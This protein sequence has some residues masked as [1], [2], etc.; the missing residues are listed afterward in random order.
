MFIQRTIHRLIETKLFHHKAIVV[1]GPR[2]VGKTTLMK[3]ILKSHP[4]KSLYLNCDEPDVRAS[5]TNKTSTEL[6][7]YIGQQEL[8]VIDEAQR[9]KNIGLTLKLLIDAAPQI[10]II[11]TGSSAFELSNRISE[12]LTGRTYEYQLFPLSH[13]E[14]LTFSNQTEIQR[15]LERRLIYGMYPDII[16]NDS[17]AETLLRNITKNYLY[18]DVLEYERIKNPDL[19]EKLLQALALQIGNEVSYTELAQILGVDK[20]TV[21]SYIRILEQ[22]FIIYIL[23]PFSRNLRKELG[24]LR[25]IYYYDLGIRNALINNF[26]PI[27]LRQ[28][29]GAIWENFLI[30]ERIKCFSNQGLFPNRY[31]WRTWDKQEIDYIEESGGQLSGFEIKW[32]DKISS[33]PKSWTVTYPRAT[34]KIINRNNYMKFVTK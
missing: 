4:K 1:Y 12:P 17:E 3:Q 20:K 11:A 8:V 9:I 31:F 22:A 10:Q 34:F 25:K 28:D 27:S 24:K 30:I 6:L 16:N 13:T 18:K 2:Q 7:A 21:A 29:T 26:N 5:L 32:G 19:L 33:A 14:I 15:L 23:K